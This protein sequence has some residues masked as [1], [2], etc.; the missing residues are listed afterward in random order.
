MAAR[1]RLPVD[2]GPESIVYS[3]SAR[4]SVRVG[5]RVADAGGGR[6]GGGGPDSLSCPAGRPLPGR[7]PAQAPGLADSESRVRLGVRAAK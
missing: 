6:G 1:R 5:L 4:L 2:Y 7:P 3:E